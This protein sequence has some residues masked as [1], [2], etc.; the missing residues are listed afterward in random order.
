MSPFDHLK[1]LTMLS[2]FDIHRGF[3]SPVK[4]ECASFQLNGS[5]PY[6]ARMF[7]GPIRNEKLY[8]WLFNTYSVSINLGTN[9]L[10]IEDWEVTNSDKEY[11]FFTQ[12]P[13][14]ER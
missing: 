4:A 2:A 13:E 3:S 10:L 5:K 6:W 14:K 8:L 7:V 11:G 9:E 12:P 1:D